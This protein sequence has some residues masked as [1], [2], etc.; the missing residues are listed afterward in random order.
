MKEWTTSYLPCCKRNPETVESISYKRMISMM[1][2]IACRPS[3]SADCVAQWLSKN[4]RNDNGLTKMILC[5]LQGAI[6][7]RCVGK[8]AV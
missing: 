7:A 6:A 1:Y 8:Y 2:E 4:M 5:M 3:R